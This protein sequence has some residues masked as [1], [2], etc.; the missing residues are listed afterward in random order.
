MIRF[1]E[2]V[3][4][5]SVFDADAIDRP[6]CT[7]EVLL[8]RSNACEEN[9]LRLIHLRFGRVCAITHIELHSLSH[10]QPDARVL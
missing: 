10:C 7:L 4:S 9:Y 1:N 3:N 6:A 8:Q 2:G 5:V